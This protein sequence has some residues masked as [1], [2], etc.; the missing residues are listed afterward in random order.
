MNVGIVGFT[1]EVKSIITFVE[2][3]V[4]DDLFIK[5][6]LTENKEEL[7]RKGILEADFKGSQ[8]S[9]LFCGQKEKRMG[10]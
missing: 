1:N 10:Q 5:F 3:K 7:S 4:V 8:G 2:S 6:V 9:R